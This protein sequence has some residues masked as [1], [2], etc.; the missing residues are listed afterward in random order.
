MRI[1][2]HLLLID[3]YFMEGLKNITL[4]MTLGFY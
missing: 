3:L 1:A 2:I 4:D